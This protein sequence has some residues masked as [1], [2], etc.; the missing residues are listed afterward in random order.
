MHPGRSSGL[1]PCRAQGFQW[2]RL[3]TSHAAAHA[4]WRWVGL[5]GT[6]PGESSPADRADRPGYW[7]IEGGTG[8]IPRFLQIQ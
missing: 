5:E 2:R 4:L 7:G 1:L 3:R 6:V 8:G